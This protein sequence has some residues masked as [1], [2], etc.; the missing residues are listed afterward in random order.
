MFLSD[1][2]IVDQVEQGHLVIDPFQ[3][4]L[5]KP[6]SYVLR[7]GRQFLQWR[8]SKEPID[9]WKPNASASFLD[10]SLSTGDIILKPT[11]P[12]LG[13][14][15]EKVALPTQ[16]VGFISVLSHLARVGVTINAGAFW[17]SPGF[18]KRESTSLTLEIVSFNPS[19]IRIK[20][21][22]PIAHLAFAEASPSLSKSDHLLNTSVYEG[23]CAPSAPMLYE[24]FSRVAQLESEES[25]D[26]ETSKP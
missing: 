16:L 2:D 10:P 19:P 6:A 8:C 1:S 22:M 21:G 14:T 9:L 25:Y 18:G 4:E 7:L 5:L 17:V 12:V 11:V 13:S 24:E 23:L 20:A 3:P 26:S 15:V